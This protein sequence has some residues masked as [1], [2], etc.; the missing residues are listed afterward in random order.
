[1]IE[2]KIIW[3]N[4]AKKLRRGVAKNLLENSIESVVTAVEIYNKPKAQFKIQSYIA[5]MII[6]WTKALHS[7]FHSENIKYYYKDKKT[8]KFVKVDGENKSWDITECIKHYKYF[9][10]GVKANLEFFIQLRNKVEHRD[11]TDSDLEMIT[12]GE[13][14]SLLYNYE[15]FVISNFGEEYSINESLRFALQFSTLKTDE[16]IRSQK[17]QLSKEVL[18]IKNFIEKFRT[19]LDDDV[20]NSQSYSIKFLIV[21]KVSNNKKGD[22]AIDFVKADDL[23]TEDYDKITAIIK[24][25]KVI[26]EAVNVKRYKPKKVIDVL[27]RYFKLSN[28]DKFSPSYHHS[29]LCDYYEVKPIGNFDNPFDTKSEYCLYDDTH[30]D[31]VY[32][33]E[34]IRF[35]KNELSP[36]PLEK[37]K[38][39]KK[40]LEL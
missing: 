29:K 28:E 34:W 30:N 15:T 16:Q 40:E 6:G 33:S 37:F 7:Y 12:I 17:R 39:I 9:D 2:V 36:N 18:D 11:L 31:Y 22:L 5:L 25:K 38:E 8:K 1:M 21:P 13:C 20:F 14:Q 4:M 3:K 19:S 26:K 10:K 32:T 24:D 27:R 23:S 35:L